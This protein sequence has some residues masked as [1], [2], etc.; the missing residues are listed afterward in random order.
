MLFLTCA[1]QVN[2]EPYIPEPTLWFNGEQVPMMCDE[3]DHALEVLLELQVWMMAKA[4][5]GCA[6]GEGRCIA[7][8]M[9]FFRAADMEAFLHAL[10]AYQCVEA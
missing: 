5:E 2:A 4:P 1:H 10:K 7:E 6:A 8:V 9:M 3:I